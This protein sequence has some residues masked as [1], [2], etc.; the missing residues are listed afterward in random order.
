ML[1][2]LMARLSFQGSVSHLQSGYSIFVLG[3]GRITKQDTAIAFQLCLYIHGCDAED[4]GA[5]FS[6]LR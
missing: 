3:D 2:C 4:A 1:C 5:P 6:A